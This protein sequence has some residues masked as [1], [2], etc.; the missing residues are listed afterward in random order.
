MHVC[1]C[2]CGNETL[3]VF[4]LPRL[5]FFT[6]L[7]T[8][9]LTSC[10]PGTASHR[11]AW[12][13]QIPPMPTLKEIQE[14]RERRT[15]RN[16]ASHGI[17]RGDSA[18]PA[19]ATPSS[20]SSSV[21][22]GLGI[23]GMAAG[24]AAL[25]FRFRSLTAGPGRERFRAGSAEFRAAQQ[26]AETF[27]RGS[28]RRAEAFSETR[29]RERSRGR[30][31]YGATDEESRRRAEQQKQRDRRSETL[32]PGSLGWALGVL[33]LRSLEGLTEREAKASYH[34]LAKQCHPDTGGASAD[35]E[36]FKRIG[37][38]Y[39]AICKFLR[40]RRSAP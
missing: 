4:E 13:G 18:T 33:Q 17:T 1:V 22:F 10:R 32:S 26:A 20:P 31:R 38:A 34:R 35:A 24:Y 37:V 9:A 2:A 23:V 21:I 11:R 6:S 28:R 5:R 27:S 16:L 15:E 39:E 19:S 14:A 29:W 25:A 3:L 30:S 36:Q 12:P 40:S 7:A 8:R